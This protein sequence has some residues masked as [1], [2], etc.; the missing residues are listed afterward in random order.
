M[1]RRFPHLERL[2]ERDSEFGFM[3]AARFASPRPHGAL[4][5]N[6][7]PRN[8]P[9]TK[10]EQ[11]GEKVKRVRDPMRGEDPLAPA[12][13][14]MSDDSMPVHPFEFQLFGPASCLIIHPPRLS[15]IGKKHDRI[16]A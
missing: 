14:A 8:Q 12:R 10:G 7:Q 3:P 15:V 13:R 4:D 5:A 16:H 1:Q 9:E 2:P 6:R 11:R